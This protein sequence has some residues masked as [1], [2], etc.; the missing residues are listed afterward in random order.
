MPTREDFSDPEFVSDYVA[1][2]Y[3][4]ES[5]EKAL[6]LEKLVGAMKSKWA[7]SQTSAIPSSTLGTQATLQHKEE[8][9]KQIMSKV[10][11][12]PPG[13]GAAPLFRVGEGFASINPYSFEGKTSTVSL[14]AK[15][16]RGDPPLDNFEQ[17]EWNRSMSR[18]VQLAY[19]SGHNVIV[20]FAAGVSPHLLNPLVQTLANAG[21]SFESRWATPQDAPRTLRYVHPDREHEVTKNLWDTEGTLL[22]NLKLTPPDR[23]SRRNGLPDALRRLRK[24]PPLR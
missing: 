18:L 16:R 22:R 5:L 12:L 17:A 23:L 9:S 10:F 21:F 1:A 14:N 4:P 6:F 24:I 7:K 2:K 15:N 19:D 3:G 13:S 20:D 8:V 11:H